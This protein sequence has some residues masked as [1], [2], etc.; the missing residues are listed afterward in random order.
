[1]NVFINF[2]GSKI[3]SS[4]QNDLK[5]FIFYWASFLRLRYFSTGDESLFVMCMICTWIAPLEST[6]TLYIPNDKLLDNNR[7]IKLRLCSRKLHKFSSR[8]VSI[9]WL[10][11]CFSTLFFAWFLH[12]IF[13]VFC[14]C[15][16]TYLSDCKELKRQKKVKRSKNRN[17]WNRTN[18]V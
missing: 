14:V 5:F 3:V 7:N 9:T 16:Y 1:M 10:Q 13:W 17:W 4:F 18:C 11:V 6:P 15:L 8:L 12:T 2:T